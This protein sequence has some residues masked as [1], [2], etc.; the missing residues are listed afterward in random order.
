MSTTNIHITPCVLRHRGFATLLYQEFGLSP[1]LSID[2]KNKL[3]RFRKRM[4]DYFDAQVLEHPFIRGHINTQQKKELLADVVAKCTFT[5][6]MLAP[7]LQGRK[8]GET[9][10]GPVVGKMSRGEAFYNLVMIIWTRWKSDLVVSTSCALASVVKKLMR[11]HA[12]SR[13]LDVSRNAILREW[14]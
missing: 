6:D 12:V 3:E 13:Q 7:F 5:A 2:D 4:I 1:S 10:S 11:F 8:I 14:K 9:G